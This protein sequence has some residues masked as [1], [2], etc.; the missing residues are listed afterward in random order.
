MCGSYR[1][2]EWNLVQANRESKCAFTCANERDNETY[3]ESGKKSDGQRHHMDF[4]ET[5]VM[6]PFLFLVNVNILRITMP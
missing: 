6:I 4:A 3:N 1:I 2:R 5:L